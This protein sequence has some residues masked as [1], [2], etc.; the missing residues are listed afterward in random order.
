MSSQLTTLARYKAYAGITNSSQD[1]LISLMIT[2]ASGA[3]ERYL[4]RTLASTTYKEWFDGSGAP[5]LRI[6]QYPI[7]ALY[8][9]SIGTRSVATISNT[10]ALVAW[11][12]LSFDGLN[13]TL[14][15]I[16]TSGVE[17]PTVLPVATYKTITAMQTAVN[18]VSGWSC[19]LLSPEYG[20]FPSSMLRP[21]YGQNALGSC[22]ADLVLP[23][24]SI[25]S[26]IIDQ[27]MI[28]LINSEQFPSWDIF[29]QT[30]QPNRMSALQPGITPPTFS[31]GF[32]PGSKNIFVWFTAGYTLPSDSP[33]SDGTL[34]AGL[35]LLVN[36]II[37]DC[38]AS[39]KINSNMSSES[40]GDYSYS[41]RSTTQGAVGSAIENRK[42]DLNQYRRVS[43]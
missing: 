21:L 40:I 5:E 23:D 9:V 28:E 3:I 10:S 43:I 17:T 4:R 36:Q 30:Q 11:A 1:A 19:S 38:L 27:D 7:T 25:S 8:Q 31:Y 24:A 32:P 35:A 13:L 6:V 18:N 33:A 16:S 29:P 15:E 39:T 12:S 34:P 14:M 37:A 2:E 20:I 26:K 42:R 22:L 41:L